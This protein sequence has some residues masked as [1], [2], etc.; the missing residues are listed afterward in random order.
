MHIR[1]LLQCIEFEW[2]ASNFSKNWLKHQV[3]YVECEQIFFNEPLLVQHDTQ[4]S[5]QEARYYALGRTDVNRR[6]F[7]IFTTRHQKIRIISAR[8]MSKKER[9]IYEKAS[10]I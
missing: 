3:S 4:H 10:Q 5:Q 6:L 9:G 2:D 7:V 8:D 1:E